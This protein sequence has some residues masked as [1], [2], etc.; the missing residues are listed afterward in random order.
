[1]RRCT[2]AGRRRRGASSIGTIPIPG[3]RL[4][5]RQGSEATTEVGD[6]EGSLL[7]L[8]VE[9]RFTLAI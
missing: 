9:K 6:G 4:G 5:E 1:V 8:A 2:N 7:G 3:F